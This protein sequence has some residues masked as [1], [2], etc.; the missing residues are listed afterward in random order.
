VVLCAQTDGRKVF[1]LYPE[2]RP[3]S[4]PLP[5]SGCYWQPP[6]DAELCR[7]RC[8]SLAAVRPADVLAEVDAV[9]LPAI[10]CGR[11]MLTLDKLAAL[12]DALLLTAGLPGDLAELGVCR[13]GAAKLIGHLQP[14]A[15]LHLFD[16]FA[17]IPE[18][19]SRGPLTAGTFA[20]DSPAEVAAFLSNPRAVLHVGK[21]PATAPA[22]LELRFAHIDMDIYQSTRAAIACLAPRLV[23]GGVLLFDDY[24]WHDC[25]GVAQAVHEAGLEPLAR[26]THNQAVWRKPCTV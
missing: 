16:T 11:T 2:A 14:D 12:R 5:C 17:G 20:G 7:P 18:D 26:P 9:R 4:G 6:F 21:F 23:P 24:G 1:G 3:L 10:A 25:P 19:D 13:G 8:P 15:R 22:E